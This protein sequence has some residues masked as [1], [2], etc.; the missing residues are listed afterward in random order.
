MHT[1]HFMTYNDK[2]ARSHEEDMWLFAL[3]HMVCSHNAMVQHGKETGPN[4]WA[5]IHLGCLLISRRLDAP[6]MHFK[7]AY[8]M[9]M[10]TEN[11]KL[12]SMYHGSSVPL[13]YNST[14][15]HVT[16]QYHVVFNE[17]FAFMKAMDP[18]IWEQ[19]MTRLDEKSHSKHYSFPVG[20]PANTQ[21]HD[22]ASF[23]NGPFAGS[24]PSGSK[25][26]QTD[27]AHLTSALLKRPA[28]SAPKGV[29]S[30]YACIVTHS[31][32]SASEGAYASPSNPPHSLAVS[33]PDRVLPVDT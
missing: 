29:S 26:P 15:T 22:F 23:W 5:M 10:H 11:G 30:T 20:D 8:K 17:S 33:A 27:T 1:Q 19:L 16:P 31:A 32:V 28:E 13:L 14:T 6:V 4:S 9:V 3:H 2:V 7:N 18:V 25:Q 21:H 12:A 24:L